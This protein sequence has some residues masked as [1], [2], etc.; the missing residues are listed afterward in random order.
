[1]KKYQNMLIDLE[2]WV[3]EAQATIRTEIKLTNANIV[4][5]QIR[6]K[7]T[8]EADLQTRSSQLET[9]LSDVKTL[10]I[11]DDIEDLVKNM[12]CNLSTLQGVMQD[13]QTCLAMRLSNLQ[14]PCS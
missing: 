8:L 13:T 4:R 10:T 2:Q 5:E 7:K 6:A 11:S 12:T 14:V 9:L 1:M 3:L